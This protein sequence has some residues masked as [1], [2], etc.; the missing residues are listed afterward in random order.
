VI[1]TSSVRLF[2]SKH[3]KGGSWDPDS[4]IDHKKTPLLARLHRSSVS[5]LKGCN[6]QHHGNDRYGSENSLTIVGWVDGQKRLK[7]L[8]KKLVSLVLTFVCA[9]I[10]NLDAI[11]PV[12]NDTSP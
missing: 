6:S 1:G 7:S 11:H 8:P 9:Q 5:E 3:F 12:L 4:P 10:A 2:F